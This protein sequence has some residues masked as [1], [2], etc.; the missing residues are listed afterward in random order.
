MDARRSNTILTAVC[1]VVAVVVAAIS[2]QFWG[3]WERA[4]AFGTAFGALGFL[5]FAIYALAVRFLTNH[6]RHLLRETVMVL[7]NPGIGKKPLDEAKQ[8]WKDV[9]SDF[10]A[11]QQISHKD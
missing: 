3:G 7:R 6:V 5:I 10:V 1:I 11:I 4:V 9:E 8:A 2:G